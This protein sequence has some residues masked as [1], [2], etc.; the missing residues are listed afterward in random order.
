MD[1]LM[2]YHGS[3]S[4]LPT[5][6]DPQRYDSANDYALDEYLITPQGN[7][8]VSEWRGERPRYYYPPNVTFESFEVEF[9][10]S[11]SPN[12]AY[13]ISY[14]RR[15]PNAYL[16]E[17]GEYANH[18]MISNVKQYYI[19]CYTIRK[20]LFL[21]CGWKSTHIYVNGLDVP[22]NAWREFDWIL[23]RRLENCP[24]KADLPPLPEVEPDKTITYYV[25]KRGVNVKETIPFY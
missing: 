25:K 12:Y 18:A 22:Y 10:K 6:L 19:W 4:D 9:S 23:H 20:L 16:Q 24:W 1:N 5:F 11:R 17:D 3:Y 7:F 13:A 14:L 21:A 15:L 8:D 2:R